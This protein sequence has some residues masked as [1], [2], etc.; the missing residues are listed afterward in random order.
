M[1]FGYAPAGL[2][3]RATDVR[4]HTVD[5]VRRLERALPAG[6]EARRARDRRRAGAAEPQRYRLLHGAG[7]D[8]GAAQPV[9]LIVE[10]AARPRNRRRPRFLR[11]A[12]HLS[13]RPEI[14]DIRRANISGSRS[15]NGRKPNRS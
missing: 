3:R 9:E 13:S 4:D 2:S 14:S 1:V 7:R 6:A 10:I 5:F 11:C 8:R 15:E 12:A